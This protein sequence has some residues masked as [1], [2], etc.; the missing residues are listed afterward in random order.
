MTALSNDGTNLYDKKAHRSIHAM[1][2]RIL[3]LGRAAQDIDFICPL[4][5]HECTESNETFLEMFVYDRTYSEQFKR[6]FLRQFGFKKH[7]C[8]LIADGAAQGHHNGTSGH[9]G[10][11]GCNHC[12]VHK[13]FKHLINDDFKEDD[14]Y[15]QGVLGKTRTRAGT[16]KLMQKFE[17]DLEKELIDRKEYYV[18]RAG[19][20]SA[21]DLWLH[22]NLG[23][24]PGHIA[25]TWI[26]QCAPAHPRPAVMKPV[27]DHPKSCHRCTCRRSLAAVHAQVC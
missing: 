1:L 6:F 3:S 14:V 26:L 15:M 19:S 22:P 4:S 5:L 27:C 23:H 20:E 17:K 7:L 12:T 8:L 16:T 18:K 9:G 2:L 13:S 10:S 25:H 11:C 21:Y 24:Q